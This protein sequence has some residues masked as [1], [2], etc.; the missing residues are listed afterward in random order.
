MTHYNHTR[1]A[2]P[3]YIENWP[4]VHDIKGSS[5]VVSKYVVLG[6]IVALKRKMQ[7]FAETLFWIPRLFRSLASN[8]AVPPGDVKDAILK[9]S[10]Y[11]VALYALVWCINQ[12]RIWRLVLRQRKFV[13]VDHIHGL[14]AQVFKL[15]NHHVKDEKAFSLGGTEKIGAEDVHTCLVRPSWD[16]YLAISTSSMTLNGV[17]TAEL[18]VIK[19]AWTKSIDDEAIEYSKSMN[20]DDENEINVLEPVSNSVAE[21]ND[22]STFRQ[23][24]IDADVPDA[25]RK[26]SN[27]AAK[28]IV[29]DYR[30]SDGKASAYILSGPPGCGKSTTAREAVKQLSKSGL[31]A[32]LYAD[33]NPTR[34]GSCIWRIIS[35]YSTKNSPVVFVIEEFDDPLREIMKGTIRD[36]DCLRRDAISK[37]SWNSMLDRFARMKHVILIMTTNKTPEELLTLCRGDT[38]L[39]R[40]GRVKRTIEF[41]NDDD[42]NPPPPAS[43]TDESNASWSGDSAESLGRKNMRQER[44]KTVARVQPRRRPWV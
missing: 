6:A 44:S 31:D 7:A 23:V 2:G 8:E 40:P 21:C 11:A 12:S 43:T 42:E 30:Q 25:V 24:A 15:L 34:P 13:V 20:S 28:T 14:S 18:V 41:S 38:S 26:R 37:S 39:L 19:L 29:D 9:W 33:Y 5:R 1:D 27:V 10:D 4:I 35:D 17:L 3:F 22:L 16:P 36:S 32:F